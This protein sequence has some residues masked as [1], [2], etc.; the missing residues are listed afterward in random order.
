MKYK[1]IL[2]QE[3]YTEIELEAESLE[4][5]K[6]LVMQGEFKDE[7]VKDVTVKESSVD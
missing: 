6:D 2:Y 3:T 4:A 1:V 5:A 7:D